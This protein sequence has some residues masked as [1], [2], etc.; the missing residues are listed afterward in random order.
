[1]WK[2]AKGFDAADIHKANDEKF[3][4]YIKNKPNHGF[5]PLKMDSWNQPQTSWMFNVVL[6]LSSL[7]KARYNISDISTDPSFVC[8]S[9]DI[10]KFESS[11]KQFYFFGSSMTKNIYRNYSGETTLQFWLRGSETKLDSS[12]PSRKPA[13]I[14][15]LAPKDRPFSVD[16]SYPH[17]ELEQPFSKIQIILRKADMSEFRTFDLENPIV[18]NVEFGSASYEDDAGL[19]I[20]MTVHY[21]HWSV[22]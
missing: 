19:K 10:P 15:L 1:M 5:K 2:K 20:S 6:E 4:Q 12:T 17:K 13:L 16:D 11:T 3:A 18:T 14:D 8:I 7:V 22:K 21:D 9:A